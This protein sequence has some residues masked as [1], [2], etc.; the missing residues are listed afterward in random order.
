MTAIDRLRSALG[1]SAGRRGL[2]WYFD[3]NDGRLIDKWS[4]YFDAYEAHFGR[5]RG[6]SP[7]L[8]ELGISHGGSLEMWRWYFGA[9]ATIVGIDIEERVAE[10]D[11]GG[12]HVHVGSQSDPEFLASL[13]ERY[14]PFDIVIDD[15]SH[16]YADQRASLHALWDAV[17]EGGVYL[18]EDVHTSYIERYEGGLG[19]DDTFIGETRRLIDELHGF[20]HADG[21]DDMHGTVDT[22]SAWTGTLGGI[23]VYDS[24]VVLDKI[25]RERPTRRMTGRPAFDD[26]YGYPADEMIDDAHRAQLASLNRPAARLRRA[27]RDP[28][29]AWARVRGRIGR[30]S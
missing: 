23:H 16:W 22:S 18:V 5:F 30:P 15:G 14:G 27:A 6:R 9:S 2:Q 21:A 19:R 1:A 28:R 25:S 10:L 24:I 8:L 7:R 26:I 12:A 4:H 29:G 11:G 17:A 20:W 13:V 3:R